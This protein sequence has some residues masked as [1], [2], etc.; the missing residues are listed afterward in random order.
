MH[1]PAPPPEVLAAPDDRA[2]LAVWADRL[3]EAGD[4]YGEFLQLQLA[5]AQPATLARARELAGQH[6]LAWWS[7][8]GARRLCRPTLE[9]RPWGLAGH[10]ELSFRSAP[11]DFARAEA[12]PCASLSALSFHQSLP[13]A[14][15]LRRVR[16]LAVGAVSEEHLSALLACF[17]PTQLTHLVLPLRREEALARCEGFLRAARGLESLTL[18]LGTRLPLARLLDAV[19]FDA[20][21]ALTLSCCEVTAADAQ[22]L[23]AWAARAPVALELSVLSNDAAPAEPQE[24][25]FAAFLEALEVGSGTLSLEQGPGPWLRLPLRA[26]ASP[27]WG[28]LGGLAVRGGALPSTAPPPRTLERLE[29]TVGDPAVL[30]ALDREGWLA[31]PER[32]TLEPRFRG[33]PLASL[34]EPDTAWNARVLELRTLESAQA[35]LPLLD[36][37]RFEGLEELK[38]PARTLVSLLTQAAHLRP[39]VVEIDGPYRVETREW[40]AFFASEAFARLEG[41]IIRGASQLHAAALEAFAQALPT[42]R[43]QWAALARPEGEEVPPLP[44]VA[45]EVE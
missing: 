14:R 32:L 21:R 20:L 44:G 38:L 24:E 43:L 35:L 13:A 8:A 23:S 31:Q 19:P 2:R 30:Q 22:R 39:K 34:L 1:A 41:L 33:A 18:K 12:L 42:S 25:G 9:P 37:P 10:L 3:V 28:R 11:E 36:A 4:P 7:A 17:E 6:H 5:P 15:F 45:F 29:M 27:S 26:L 16:Q 40:R